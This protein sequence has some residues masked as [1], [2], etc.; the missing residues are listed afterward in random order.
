MPQGKIICCRNGK[1]YKWLRSFEDPKKP[2]KCIHKSERP[3]AEKLALKRYLT[4][5]LKEANTERNALNAYLH[6]HQKGPLPSEQMLTEHPEYQKLLSPYFKPRSEIISEWLSEP[7]ETNTYKEHRK[8]FPTCSGVL[9]RSKSEVIIESIL[10]KNHIPFRYECK[11][12]LGEEDLFPDFT[13]LHPKTC[14]LYYWEH[15]GLVEKPKYLQ[16]SIS[17]LYTYISNGI[18]PGHN[19]ITTYETKDFPLDFNTIEEIVKYYFLR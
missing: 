9:V 15:L 12:Q 19:L 6:S 1:Y 18:I 4:E 11:L 17:K 16:R 14:Q 13:I 10:F 7:Y 2:T 5:Q 3:L 8:K